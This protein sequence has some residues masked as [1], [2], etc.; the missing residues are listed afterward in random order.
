MLVELSTFNNTFK[1]LLALCFLLI[2]TGC[3]KQQSVEKIKGKRIEINE[4]IQIDSIINSFITPYHNRVQSELD[5]VLTYSMDTY[6][7]SDGEYNTAIG[8][9]LA[10]IVY[11][12]GNL[13]YAKRTGQNIDMVMLNHGGIRS[14]LSK[15]PV[16]VKDV[17]SIMPFENSIVVVELSGKII[18][19]RLVPFLMQKKIAH[20]VS[21]IK[22][23]FN[24]EDYPVIKTINNAPIDPDKMYHIATND[25]LYFGGDNMKFFQRGKMTPLNYKI[26]NA[27][28]DYF[29]KH[30]TIR[31]KRDDRF[32]KI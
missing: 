12:Q 15:G 9:L 19:K 30:D 13:I 14:I 21:G 5:S 28:I 7:K 17:Y 2:F 23:H 16:T 22:I 24:D 1:Q 8:N 3:S 29:K 6:S 11:E 10:D 32:L 20:P 25:Y 4:D 27:M 18:L 26:R 31:P